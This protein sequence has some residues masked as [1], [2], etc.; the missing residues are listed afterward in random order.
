MKAYE[1]ND[2]A[3]IL[4]FETLSVNKDK[5]VVLSLAFLNFEIKKVTEAKYDYDAL[6]EKA[7]YIKFDVEDQV[8]NHG[9]EISKS[10]LQWWSEQGSEAQKVL[11]P[12]KDDAS[13]TVL[14]DFIV[15]RIPSTRLKAAMCRGIDFDMRFLEGIMKDTGHDMPWPHWAYRDTRSLIDGL[16]AFSIDKNGF[17]PEGL[18]QKFVAHDA[19]H[20]IAMDIMRMQTILEASF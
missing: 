13:I 4:D 8:K 19:R 18:E 20:D 15:E 5:G 14:H 9:R 10:T 17:I 2:N 7:Q 11:K 12:S 3:I 1:E 6:V 16:A